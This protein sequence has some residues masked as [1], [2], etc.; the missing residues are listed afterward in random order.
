MWYLS[1]WGRKAYVRFGSKADISLVISFCVSRAIPAPASGLRRLE[2]SGPFHA[3]IAPM[4][5]T[6]AMASMPRIISVLW[7]A[8]GVPPLG[9][10]TFDVE[11]L[12]REALRVLR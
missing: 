9:A 10:A 5:L 11:S 6:S 12:I 7:L 3:T 2:W 1:H 8:L 4:R